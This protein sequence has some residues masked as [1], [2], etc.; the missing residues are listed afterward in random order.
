VSLSRRL[1][2]SARG[3]GSFTPPPFDVAGPYSPALDVNEAVLTQVH[4][5]TT[6]SDGARTPA[7]MVADYL[8]KG[9]GALAITDHDKITTQPAGITTALPGIEHSP[10]TS[11]IIA[12]NSSYLRGSTTDPQEIVDGIVAAGGQAHIAHPKWLRDMSTAELIALDDYMGFE[13]H[14]AHC[15]PGAGQNPVTYPGFAV[16]RWDAV[17]AGGKRDAWGFAVDDR[18]AASAFLVYDVGRLK[19][20]V[21][22]NDVAGVMARLASGNFVADVSNY[23]VTPG[24]PTRTAEG[25]GLTCA[26]ATRIEAWGASG[27]LAASDS[28]TLSYAYTG[29]E[30]YVR[31]VAWGDYDETFGTALSDRWQALDGSWAV[32]GGSLN[33]SSDG[34]TRR[35]ILRRHREGD[36]Q[37]EADVEV[38]SGGTDSIA[39]MFNV[40]SENY[41]YMLRIGE[42]SVTGY[43]NQLAV[44]R[45]TNNSFGNNSQLANFAFNPDAATVYTM[46]MAYTSAAGRIQAKVWEPGDTEPDWQ[47]DVASTDWRHGMFGIRAN[48]SCKVHRLHVN[49]F[50]TYYQPISVD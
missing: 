25:V 3:G 30:Q 17:L 5:H 1:L 11:H 38:S 9:Y 44:A 6:Q 50:K 13:I 21:D 46:K 43:N 28:N 34:T 33:V 49:G 2:T 48:R 42:S 18:H 7:Q 4:C 40:L 37:M 12:T 16:D 14:N 26:G 36:F 10:T 23:G 29:G 31:A 32:S 19:V 20:F 8:S 22:D 41:Y 47:I 15:I 24:Y 45:T 27:L 39:L 35:M